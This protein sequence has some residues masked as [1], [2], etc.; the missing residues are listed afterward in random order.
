MERC[1]GVFFTPVFLFWP[2]HTACGILVPLPGIEPAPP[3]LK[4]WS[5]YYQGSPKKVYIYHIDECCLTGAHFA[6]QGTWSEFRGSVSYL[7]RVGAVLPASVGGGWRGFPRSSSAQDA[8]PPRVVCGTSNN[9]E[10][11]QSQLGFSTVPLFSP[12]LF[13]FS[14][15]L[16]F[17]SLTKVIN[18]QV[19]FIGHINWYKEESR[20]YRHERHFIDPCSM[21]LQQVRAFIVAI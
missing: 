4:V 9:A 10:V 2:H 11:E 1:K 12:K 19:F 17:F 7:S 16:F 20:S 15:K 14:P 13:L 5:L 18:T 3:V 8:L 6:P 21:H